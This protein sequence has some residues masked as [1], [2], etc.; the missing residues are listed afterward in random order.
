MKARQVL[1]QLSTSV[2][3]LLDQFKDVEYYSSWNLI[4]RFWQIE[5]EKGD[6]AKTAFSTSWGHYEYN[7][8]PFG[9]KRALATFQRLIT[10]VLD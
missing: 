4:S 2:K 10:K 5:I 3:R 9:L 1:N 7:V 8:M 6:K